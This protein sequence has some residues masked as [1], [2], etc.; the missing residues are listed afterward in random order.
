MKKSEIILMFIQLPLDFILLL[1]AGWSAY[2]LRFSDWAVAWRPV[3]FNL[4]FDN[5]TSML[6]VVAVV[7]ILIFALS[8]LYSTDPNRKLLPDLARVLLGC[9]AGLSAVA[10]YVLFRQTPFDSRFLVVFGWGFAVSYVCFGR[11]VMRGFKALLYRSNIGLRCVVLIGENNSTESIV[12]VLTTRRE[13]G[14]DVLG[15]YEHLDEP[16]SRIL[17]ELDLDEIIFLNPRAHEDEAL[18][19]IDLCNERHIVFKYSADLFAT[20]SSHMRVQPLAG[21]PIVELKRTALDGWGRVLKR[22][23]DIVVSAVLII[24]LAPVMLAVAFIIWCETGRPIIYKNER[25]GIRGQ[26]FFTFKFRSMYQ[27]DSTGSQFG[28]DGEKAEA[29]EQE[30]IK[31]QNSKAGP[32]YK[33]AN[34]PRVTPFGRWLRQWSLDELPQFF[35]VLSGSMSLVGP[36]P[37]QP[38]EVGQYHAEHKR[39]LIIKPGISGLAQISGRSDLSFTDEIRLDVF[40]IEHWS[41]FLDLVIF[42]KTPFILFKKRRVL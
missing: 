12:S 31:K 16:T 33:I 20:Y 5:F 8:G 28:A 35:N 19:A 29:R 32:I 10:V 25:V 27:K 34:D 40:Y 36:R 38:R 11:L 9:S 23:T 24:I 18:R 39:V 26:N 42:F 15:V 17:A 22:V 30:L 41:L 2:W 13:L 21:V 6:V 1:L 4:T 37:H 3:L 7:W 14:Y